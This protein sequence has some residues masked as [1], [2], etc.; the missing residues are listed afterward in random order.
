VIASEPYSKFHLAEGGSLTP[1]EVK[2]IMLAESD[3]TPGSIR[4]NDH[5]EGNE[6]PCRCAKNKGNDPIFDREEDGS[7]RVR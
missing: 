6:S 7:Y 2:E 5:A 3:I 4:P 1:R